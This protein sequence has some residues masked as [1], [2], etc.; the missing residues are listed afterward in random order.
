[1]VDGLNELPAAEEARLGN[2]LHLLI[3]AN[4]GADEN[5]PFQRAVTAATRPIV[6]L[7][8]RKDVDVTIT[9]LDSNEVNAFS[10]LGG[11][12]YVTRGLFNL[13]ATE[14]EFQFVVGHELAHLEMKHAQALVAE[15]TRAGRL[16]GV[17]TLP[18]LYHQIAEG[19]TV[20]QEN[21][22]DDWVLERMLRLGHTKREC[23]A[24]I[25]KFE[26]LSDQQGFRNGRKEP[27]TPLGAPVQDVDNHYRS[28]PAAW[29][30]LTRL[31][32]RLNQPRVPAAGDGRRAPGR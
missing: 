4:H 12:V 29:E 6:D 2:L 27:R 30:R 7:R 16:A 24:F 18:A 20:A 23:L 32:G 22:A 14:E 11:Y 26:K 5:S 13:A 15:A 9:V 3:L 21:A 25:R 1:M 10:H 17:G 28:L 31:E 19:Y 8:S